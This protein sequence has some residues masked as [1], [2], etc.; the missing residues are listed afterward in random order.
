MVSRPFE[1]YPGRYLSVSE[2]DLANQR[3]KGWTDFH[4]EDFCHRCGYP[5]V[6]WYIDSSVWNPIMR[7]P[8]NWGDWQ[9]IVCIPCFIE[10]AE[11]IFGACNWRIERDESRSENLIL[12]GVR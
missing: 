6:S 3:D 12:L 2:L 5:N 8:V 9:E 1:G 11:A 7:G 4:P 10:V